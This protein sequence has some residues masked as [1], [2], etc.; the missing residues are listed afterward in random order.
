MAEE[1]AKVPAKTE[2]PMMEESKVEPEATVASGGEETEPKKAAEEATETEAVEGTT[3][4]EEEPKAV[5][6]EGEEPKK[7]EA[8]TQ[9][10]Q[11]S[12][13]ASGATTSSSD[14]DDASPPASEK[15][16]TAGGGN[17]QFYALFQSIQKNIE[18]L[19]DSTKQIEKVNDRLLFHSS[20]ISKEEESSLIQKV[21][22]IVQATNIKARD[23]SRLIEQLRVE[24]AKPTNM[25]GGVIKEESEKSE[26]E[27][28][29]ES[30]DV[31]DKENICKTVTRSF[32]DELLLY[33]SALQDFKN[34]LKERLTKKIQSI[35]KGASEDF[36]DMSL[37]SESSR[38]ALF[39]DIMAMDEKDLSEEAAKDLKDDIAEKY[40]VIAELSNASSDMNKIFL[41]LASM[42]TKPPSETSDSDEEPVARG[43]ATRKKGRFGRGNSKRGSLI[44]SLL[45]S[46]TRTA[47]AEGTSSS[48]G[49]A[50][51]GTEPS[52]E[53]AAAEEEFKKRNRLFAFM[54]KHRKASTDGAKKMRFTV[55]DSDRPRKRRGTRLSRWMTLFLLATVGLAAI[56]GLVMLH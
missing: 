16:D 36:V 46:R 24:T 43:G 26:E 19:N 7:E 23:S 55:S 15:S 35:R 6:K 27:K 28:A 48:A 2:G 54:Q 44:D 41:S 40:V 42:A 50:S 51:S 21:S 34:E 38:Y 47:A 12:A 3:E 33:Q 8:A 1:E 17:N 53:S 49:N 25:G 14:D 20:T 22:D 10:P 31:G 39:R 29:E 37:R 13:A 45:G 9:V 5:A 52:A 4:K 30:K 56:V 32:T 18:A 11:A